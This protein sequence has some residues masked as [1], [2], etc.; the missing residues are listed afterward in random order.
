MSIN[1]CSR[2]YL[3]YILIFNVLV[4][5]KNI[6][7]NQSQSCYDYKFASLFHLIVIFMIIV[8]QNDKEL[9][10]IIIACILVIMLI[11][12]KSVKLMI[13]YDGLTLIYFMMAMINIITIMN[14]F[15]EY[16]E[17]SEEIIIITFKTNKRTFIKISS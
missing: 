15:N 10:R 3:M 7:L 9:V 14:L 16:L 11:D 4:S 5:T 13:D 17:N 12:Y 1:S 8:C 6:C 2:I